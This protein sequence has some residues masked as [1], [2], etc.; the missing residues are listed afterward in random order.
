MSIC[1]FPIAQ[2]CQIQCVTVYNVCVIKPCEK[3]TCVFEESGENSERAKQNVQHVNTL[4]LI[5]VVTAK[6]AAVLI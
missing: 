1:V 4:T 3:Q 2:C 5:W 6:S